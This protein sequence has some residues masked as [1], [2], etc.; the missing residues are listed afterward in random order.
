M[1][2]LADE[3]LPYFSRFIQ[4]FSGGMASRCRVESRMRLLA[5]W[6]MTWSTSLGC[7][8]L[9]ASASRETSSSART[10]TL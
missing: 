1:G 10:A 3:V 2:T 9:A 8:P 6:A 4:H 5:W 7:I